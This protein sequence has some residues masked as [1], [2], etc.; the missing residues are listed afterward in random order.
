MIFFVN[1][2]TWKQIELL[3]KCIKVLRPRLPDLRRESAQ[4]ANIKSV[5][6][7]KISYRGNHDLVKKA[8]LEPTPT[9][10]CSETR[11][12]PPSNDGVIR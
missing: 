7:L 6:P 10:P 12:R 4:Y 11:A 2:L 3:L 1:K 9:G 5:S 8:K